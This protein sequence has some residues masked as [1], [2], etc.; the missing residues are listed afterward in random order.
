MYSEHN[1][2]Y[3]TYASYKDQKTETFSQKVL[4]RTDKIL[5]TTQVI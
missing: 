1:M 5:F 3:V 4:Y 2:Q